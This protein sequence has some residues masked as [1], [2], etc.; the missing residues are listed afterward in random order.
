MFGVAKKKTRPP[1]FK[2]ECACDKYL[3]GSSKCWI[4][5]LKITISKKFEVLRIFLSNF[6]PFFLASKIAFLLI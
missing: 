3:K 6:I 5:P 1:F 2:D 4:V